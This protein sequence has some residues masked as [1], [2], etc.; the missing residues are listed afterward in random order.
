MGTW[1]LSSIWPDG[2]GY[3]DDFLP[4]GGIRTWSE[5]R[6]VRNGYFFSPAGNLTGIWYFTTAIILDCEQVKLCSFY[7]INYDLF[8]L[9]NFATRLSQIFIEYC[10]WTCV[11]YILL[12]KLIILMWFLHLEWETRQVPD[13]RPKSDRYRYKFLPAT[14]LLT[15]E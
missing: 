10:F 12:I 13:T 2:Y 5:S 7:Y 15:D 1:Y 14:S 6:R 9:L 8:W 11:Y 4:M 3:M